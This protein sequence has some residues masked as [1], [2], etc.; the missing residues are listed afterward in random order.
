MKLQRDSYKEAIER[1]RSTHLDS[2]PAKRETMVCPRCGT[3]QVISDVPGMRTCLKCGFEFRP[4][5][6]V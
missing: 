3:K 1:V 2:V 4:K 6:H 5:R